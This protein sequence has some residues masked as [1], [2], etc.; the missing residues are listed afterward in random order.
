MLWK[1][2]LHRPCSRLSNH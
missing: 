2:N 1:N